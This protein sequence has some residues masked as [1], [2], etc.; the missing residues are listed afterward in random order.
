MS[1]YMWVFNPVT[2]STETAFTRAKP[3]LGFGP[4]KLQSIKVK[5][6]VAIIVG[7]K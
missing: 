5:M 4:K 7:T 3:R 2:S 1:G 6:L